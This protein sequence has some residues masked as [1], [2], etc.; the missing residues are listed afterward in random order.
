MFSTPQENQKFVLIAWVGLLVVFG[1]AWR[2]WLRGPQ[3]LEDKDRELA[4]RDTRKRRGSD[5]AL[6]K[7]LKAIKRRGDQLTKVYNGARK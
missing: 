3:T 1:F 2:D 5:S 7:K 6:V 4:L